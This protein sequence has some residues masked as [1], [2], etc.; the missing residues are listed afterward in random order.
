MEKQIE[1]IQNIYDYNWIYSEF[2]KFY[3]RNRNNLKIHKE[4]KTVENTY[5]W[6]TPWGKTPTPWYSIVLALIY[7]K[8]TKNTVTLII[9]D[10]W[11]EN[12]LFPYYK[13]I[14]SLIDSSLLYFKG[15]NYIKVIRLSQMNDAE[16]EHGELMLL[17]DSVK[18]NT[19][20][21]LQSSKKGKEYDETFNE[22][23]QQLYPMAK[24]IKGILEQN[25]IS[26]II[27]PGGMFQ[28]TGFL[29]KICKK[30]G[31][32]IN[33]F[34]SGAGRVKIGINCI[35]A[36]VGNTKA[37]YEIVSKL[38][39]ITKLIEAAFEVLDK[40]MKAQKDIGDLSKGEIVQLSA[41]GA[42]ENYDVIIFTN[43][44]HDTAALGTH[45]FYEDDSEWLL[46]TV[47]YILEKTPYTVAV[48][49]HPLQRKFSNKYAFDYLSKRFEM[50]DRFKFFSYQDKINSYDLINGAKLILVNT[51]TIGIESAM[52]GKRVIT[53]SGSYYAD[54]GFMKKCVTESVYFDEI[55]SALDLPYKLNTDEMTE[56]AVYYGLTQL[57]S[58]A[59]T[60]FT[61]QNEDYFR[62][63]KKDISELLDYMDTKLI[64][65]SLIEK[66]S[67]IR[68]QFDERFK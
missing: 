32:S 29:F 48:R 52:L 24:K 33:T 5:F 16:L 6:V 65:N 9:N 62:W 4:S 39:N 41:C 19:I 35:A 31:I 43:I 59:I 54:A 20:K 26:Y 18:Q 25:K 30:K 38:D 11:K 53:E 12:K 23:Q 10:M 17:R 15:N 63:V 60:D 27:S 57:C 14:I 22:W 67:I 8:Y 40:R 3:I 34:D 66:E 44:E 13:E 49:E 47:A 61:P 55:K 64:F 21:R 56:A 50:N 2:E 45:I 42:E 51:S 46:H 36:Q 37:C 1:S 58:N 68:K 7:Q 28:E